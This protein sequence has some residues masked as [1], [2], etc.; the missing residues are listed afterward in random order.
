MKK[1]TF[2]VVLVVALALSTLAA[3]GGPSATAPTGT[4]PAAAGAANT[5]NMT[6][7]QFDVS[8]ITIAKGSTLTFTDPQGGSPHNLVNGSQGQAQPESG[9]PAFGSGGQT[10]AA[11]ASWTTPPWNTAGTFHVTCTYHPTTMTLTV[12]VTG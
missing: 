6:G 10:V 7:V 9:V 11:G 3:C 8:T 4:T 1:F 5:V 12:T 2:L